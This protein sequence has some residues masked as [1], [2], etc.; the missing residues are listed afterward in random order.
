MK[1]A[2]I[3]ALFDRKAHAMV[4]RP[5]LGRGNGHSRASMGAGFRCEVEHEDRRQVVDQTTEPEQLMRASLAASLAM[6]Y[7]LWGARLGVA[8]EAVAV[9][10][11]CEYDARGQ[12][13]VS[14]EVAVGWLR[15]GFDVTITSAEPEEA[16][17]RVVATA[18]AHNPMLANLAP[19][20]RRVHTLTIRRA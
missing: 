2:E 20:V 16:V 5:D 10:V 7:R 3:K 13:G 15:V 11:M 18:D 9:E 4:R 14:D 19:T 17:R 1:S 12:L 6:G 8:I